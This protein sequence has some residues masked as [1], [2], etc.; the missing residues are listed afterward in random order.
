MS[1]GFVMK[2]VCGVKSLSDC[3]RT[4]SG[5]SQKCGNLDRLTRSVKPTV[6]NVLL[7]VGYVVCGKNAL[8]QAKGHGI[9]FS[10]LGNNEIE[11]G[12]DSGAAIGE[13]AGKSLGSPEISP[14]APLKSQIDS[15]K[16]IN[17]EPK[18]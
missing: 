4:L 15:K 12:R 9:Y 18:Q 17:G 8:S 16:P 7:L 11:K 10:P 5:V 13:S 6:N 3:K 14:S 2:S 1:L